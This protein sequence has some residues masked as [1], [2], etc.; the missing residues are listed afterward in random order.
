MNY[1]L[2]AI[3]FAAA[4]ALASPVFAQE[5]RGTLL[6]VSAEGNA[7]ARPD[8]ATVRVGVVTTGRTSQAALE[9]NT[10]RMTS[11]IDALRHEGVSDNDIQTS[12]LTVRPQRQQRIVSNYSAANSVEVRVRN[13]EATGRIVDAI[14]AVGGNTVQG[15]GFAF[16]AP[17]AQLDQAR[18][19]AIAE[20]RRRADLYA[21]ALGLRA[22]RTIEVTEPGAGR[23]GS[24][25]LELTATLTTDSLLNEQPDLPVVPIIPGEIST[26]A[27]VSVAFELR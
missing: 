27:Q 1:I 7:R 2:K 20:A 17:E 12:S 24:E 21:E 26:R 16:Q 9:E 23:V 14:V 3:A 25:Q 4:L 15:V 5:A 10:R 18:R 19:A 11:L 8:M 6:N 13:V 22:V